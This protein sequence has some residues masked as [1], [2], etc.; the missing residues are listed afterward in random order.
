MARSAI[1]AIDLFCGAGGLTYG[2]AKAGVDVRAGFDVDGDCAYP[3]VTNNQVAFVRSDVGALRA[4]DLATHLTGARF[5]L[6][7]G[8]APCQPFSRYSKTGRG[9]T[10]VGKWRL[11]EDFGRLV[12]EVR[13]DFVT[14]ENVPLLAHHE[15]FRFLLRSLAGYQ[16]WWDVVDPSVYGCAQQRKRLVVLASKHGAVCLAP[17]SSKRVTVRDRIGHLPWIAAGAANRKD[18]LHVAQALSPIN[19]RRIRASVP[20]GTWRDW[21]KSLRA[22]CHQRPTG[23]TYPS[24][25]GRMEWDT[26]APTMTTQ[27]FGYGNGRFGHPA[28]DRAITLREAALL[29]GFPP[30]YEFARPIEISFQRV[31]RMIGNAVPVSLAKA[32]GDAFVRHSRRL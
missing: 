21:P 7:A 10:A 24:V 30:T 27:C 32:I 5:S 1:A 4:E 3:Y 29:Q 6:L 14:M 18:S 19:L 16:V 8:C 23:A 13:P 20:G 25:Y 31:G 9:R 15:A 28:Q 2:L 26:A 11:V 17:G 22:A 12:Q